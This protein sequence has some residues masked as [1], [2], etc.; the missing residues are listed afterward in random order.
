LAGAETQGGPASGIATAHSPMTE[1]FAR[2]LQLAR[3]L[4]P[5]SHV[6]PKREHASPALGCMDG[7]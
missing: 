5:Y 3:L 4:D 2:V 6:S 7:Q 1:Q